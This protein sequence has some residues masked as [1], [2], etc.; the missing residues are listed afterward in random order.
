MALTLTSAARLLT[1]HHLLRE[2][3]RGGRWSLNPSD[4]PDA[5]TPFSDATYDS[6]KVREG[7]LLFCKGAFRAEYLSGCD[8]AGLSAYVAETEY[9]GTTTS[10][11]LIVS[12]VR[13][14]MSLLAAAFYDYPQHELT[15]IGITG[16]K[17]K[18]TTAYFVQAILGAI[19]GGKAALFSSVDNCTDGHTYHESDLTT[20]E[21]LDAF[22]MMREAADNGMQY[23]VMEV[24]SQAYK[25][26]RVYGLTFDVGAFLNISPDHISPKEHPSFEDY[27]YCKRQIVRNSRTLVLGADCDH[28][29]LILQDA[30]QA[31]V[32]VHTF[33]LTEAEPGHLDPGDTATWP[34]DGSHARFQISSGSDSVALHLAMDGDFNYANA[35]AALAIVQAAGVDADDPAVASAL[36]NVRISGRME[37]FVDKAN[38]TVA[39]VDYAHNFASVKAIIDFV[40]ERYRDRDP[41]LTLVTGSAGGKAIDRRQGIVEAAQGRVAELILTEDDPDTERAEDICAQMQGFVTDPRTASRIITDRKTAVETAMAEAKRHNGLDVVLVIGKGEERWIKRDGKHA[42]Y[43]SDTAIVR[44]MVTGR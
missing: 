22:R 35:A 1:E 44:R 23:L 15:L 37:E 30:A 18:T 24:S 40:E 27:L 29:D 33:R 13:R 7:S 17:G 25:V 43:E 5:D 9:S 8:S 41:R 38:H 6:R 28:A 20:P 11:G 4:F 32:P 36:E 26:N 3:V 34:L 12:D 31:E 21:S 14:A 16:T 2:I 10:T 42:P 39:I 19:S